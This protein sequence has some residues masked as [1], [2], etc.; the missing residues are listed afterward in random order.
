MALVWRERALLHLLL[1]LDLVIYDPHLLLKFGI[2][3]KAVNQL[4]LAFLRHA[5]A[6]GDD[7]LFVGRQ[8][9]G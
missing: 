8:G 1:C 5:L 6:S 7:A 2:A 4:V 3:V 9:R